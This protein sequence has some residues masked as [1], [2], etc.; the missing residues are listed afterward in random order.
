MLSTA[1]MVVCCWLLSEWGPVDCSPALPQDEVLA[2]IKQSKFFL[3]GPDRHGR[4]VGILQARKHTMTDVI[5]QQR[6][7]TYCIDGMLASCNT[8]SNPDGK[9]VAIFELQGAP[10]GLSLAI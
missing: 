3:Q 9:F 8:Q 2:D 10:P 1:S 7:I 6:F 5:S 4:G